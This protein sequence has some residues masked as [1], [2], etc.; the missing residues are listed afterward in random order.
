MEGDVVHAMPLHSDVSTSRIL[1]RQAKPFPGRSRRT[2][3]AGRARA[4]AA[5]E[6]EP[7]KKFD[8]LYEVY[9]QRFQRDD[10]EGEVFY[11]EVLRKS[12]L[13]VMYTG[14]VYVYVHAISETRVRIRRRLL[15]RPPCGYL[16][17]RL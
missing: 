11:R 3:G 1:C 15:N 16:I 9:R 12:Y 2:H 14:Q 10:I 13:E 8:K 4:F 5:F 7:S 6:P 17:R